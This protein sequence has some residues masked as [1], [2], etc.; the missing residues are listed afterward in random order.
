MLKPNNY[1]IQE[2]T[3]FQSIKKWWKNHFV[4]SMD[5][6]TV[7][8]L[9]KIEEISNELSKPETRHYMGSSVS[10]DYDGTSACIQYPTIHNIMVR[11]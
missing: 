7:N 2:E 1:K 4:K 6:K 5:T 11:E 3:I 8:S 10:L 9:H